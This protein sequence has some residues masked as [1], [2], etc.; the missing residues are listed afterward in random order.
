[1][2]RAILKEM[3]YLILAFIAVSSISFVVV[4]G[5]LFAAAA[6]FVNF[7]LPVAAL[8]LVCLIGCALVVRAIMDLNGVMKS[9]LFNIKSSLRNAKDDYR[10]EIEVED[11]KTGHFMLLDL[12]DR[13]AV[14]RYV[15]EIIAVGH[16]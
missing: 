3:F 1:M 15:N 9:A 12:A 5:T 4:V 8:S 11:F 10:L 13:G 16:S 2:N 7:S 14:K 6:V